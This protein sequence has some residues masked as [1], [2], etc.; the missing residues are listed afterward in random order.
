[1]GLVG[2]RDRL[3]W[4]TAGCRT[5]RHERERLNVQSEL[6]LADELTRSQLQPAQAMKRWP[7]KAAWADRGGPLRADGPQGP[8]RV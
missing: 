8:S 3:S 2:C 1:M 6:S 5:D 7:D 4:R